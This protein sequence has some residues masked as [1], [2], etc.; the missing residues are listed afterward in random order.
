MV[1]FKSK[2]SFLRITSADASLIYHW[3]PL[4]HIPIPK[5]GTDKENRI[6]MISNQAPFHRLKHKA[7]YSN[8]WRK[9]GVPLEKGNGC[10][11]GNQ[12]CNTV[13]KIKHLKYSILFYFKHYNFCQISLEIQRSGPYLQTAWVRDFL[14]LSSGVIFISY[15]CAHW[16]KLKI[17]KLNLKFKLLHWQ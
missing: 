6:I 1:F 4:H 8:N 10:W 2:K 16:R 13:F 12:Q 15:Y 5:T 17:F 3:L 7:F 9:F 11:F 14:K